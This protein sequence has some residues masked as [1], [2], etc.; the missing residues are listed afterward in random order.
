MALSKKQYLFRYFSGTGFS[1]LGSELLAGSLHELVT[2]SPPLDDAGLD[3]AGAV[4]DF[5][6]G[7][8]LERE[9]DHLGHHCG[10]QQLTRQEHP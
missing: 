10:I 4:G 9:Q 1:Q 7:K 2:L 6:A 3:S 8:L 5:A